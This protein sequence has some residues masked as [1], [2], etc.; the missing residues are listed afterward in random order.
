ME[1]R[2]DLEMEQEE[3]CAPG[4][5]S[6]RLEASGRARRVG[7]SGCTVWVVEVGG[8][9]RGTPGESGSARQ[10]W[11]A[12][13]TKIA[14]AKAALRRAMREARR[15]VKHMRSRAEIEAKLAELEVQHAA[16]DNEASTAREMNAHF[17]N[18]I[19]GLKFALGEEETL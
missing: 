19:A 4:S 1:L 18:K 3:I 15:Q 17:A 13:M 14:T 2:F 12:K 11:R 16:V 9:L 6:F 5:W 7:D 10:A 8:I